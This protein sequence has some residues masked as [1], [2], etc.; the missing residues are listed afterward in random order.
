MLE[1]IGAIAGGIFLLICIICAFRESKVVGAY[2]FLGVFGRLK[3]YLA[4]DLTFGGIACMVMGFVALFKG[5][6]E[7]IAFIPAGLVC[8]LIGLLIIRSVMRKCPDFLKG[9]CIWDMIVVTLGVSLK[10]A[11]FFIGAVWAWQSPKA[12]EVEGGGQVYL[13]HDGTAFDP[14]SGRYGE[15]DRRSRSFKFKAN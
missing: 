11:V 1:K 5:A 8:G 13:F 12:V 14:E 9:R 7:E 3:A 15:Y 2:K 4:I 6:K 10:I